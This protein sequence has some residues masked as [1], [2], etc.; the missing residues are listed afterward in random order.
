MDV[1]TNVVVNLSNY[2][3]SDPE[4]TVLSKGLKYCPTPRNINFIELRADLMQFS[5][6]LR[7]K[8]QFHQ[9]NSSPESDNSDSSDQ[10]ADNFLQHPLLRKKSYYTPPTGRSAALDAYITAVETAILSA[11]VKKVHSNLTK[12]WRNFA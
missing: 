1:A 12:Q 11:P 6:R 8:E 3:L 4:K 7:L 5:T 10:E 9:T 2:D